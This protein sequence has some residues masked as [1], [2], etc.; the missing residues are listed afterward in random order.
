MGSV[1]G[2]RNSAG[3][4]RESPLYLGTVKSQIGHLEAGAGIAGLMKM[5]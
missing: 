4:D 2:E 3:E 1:F 5:A